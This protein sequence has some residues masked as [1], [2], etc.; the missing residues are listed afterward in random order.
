MKTLQFWTCLLLCLL[1]LVACDQNEQPAIP[2]ISAITTTDPT[3]SP[4]LQPVPTETEVS[5]P[6]V[7]SMMESPLPTATD[8]TK[9][10]K[11]HGYSGYGNQYPDFE[12]WYNPDLWEFGLNN[13]LVHRGDPSCSLV[14]QTGA[15]D[16]S[17]GPPVE[18][19][20]AGRPWNYR[21]RF[22][23]SLVY[24]TPFRN[25]VYIFDVHLSEKYDGANKSRCQE[26]AE[27]VLD[28]FLLVGE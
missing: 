11:Y 14:L 4:T 5:T 18:V 16:A 22:D 20:L 26:L 3:T 21:L 23:N 2:T 12:V 10:V 13:N 8:D 9:L 19:T 15:D 24:I 1:S 27:D 7:E 6:A 28:T 25:M 17:T